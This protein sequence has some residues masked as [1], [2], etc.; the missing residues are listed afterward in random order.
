MAAPTTTASGIVLIFGS[1][2]LTLTVFGRRPGRYPRLEANYTTIERSIKGSAARRGPLTQ[3]TAIWTFDARL[4]LDQQETL[5][6]MEAAYWG[7]RGPWT[8]YDYTNYWFENGNTN[9]RA[10]APNSTAASDGTTIL[11]YPQWR[12]EPTQAFEFVEQAAGFDVV[13]FQFTETEVVSA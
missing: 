3:P 2:T 6:R 8:L 11:Y 1:Y 10:L 9:T 13:S 12:A 7:A 5:R 4:S